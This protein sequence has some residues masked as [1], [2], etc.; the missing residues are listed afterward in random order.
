MFRRTDC[1]FF[2]EGVDRTTGRYD[3][4]MTDLL[5]GAAGRVLLDLNPRVCVRGPEVCVIVFYI[6]FGC[7]LKR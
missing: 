1:H 2:D 6:S 4:R 3:R 5:N 7:F